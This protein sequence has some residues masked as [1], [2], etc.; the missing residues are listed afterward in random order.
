MKQII[1][2]LLIA[3]SNLSVEAKDTTT[4]K[5]VVTPKCTTQVDTVKFVNDTAWVAKKPKVSHIVYA[6]NSS[7]LSIFLD[8]LFPI[9]MLLLG[10]GIDRF[11]VWRG[12]KSKVRKTGK[13]WISELRSLSKPIEA[14][15]KSFGT[16]ITKYCDDEYNNDTP[17]VAI[18]KLLNGSTFSSLNKED[19]SEYLETI[20][21][22]D[23]NQEYQTILNIVANLEFI[24]AQFI[25]RWSEFERRAG[26][27][28]EQYNVNIQ[29]YR[30]YLYKIKSLIESEGCKN[31]DI[32]ELS[33][34]YDSVFGDKKEKFNIFKSKDTFIDPSIAI[35]RR[36]KQ[37]ADSLN[38]TELLINSLDCIEYLRNE[39]IYVKNNLTSAID[40]YNTIETANN[41]VLEKFVKK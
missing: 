24:H 3:L 21:G 4:I 41:Q 11:I 18:Y 34:L 37:D 5:S 39:K 33:E 10:V 9:I 13:R 7:G 19:L 2:I 26:L 32:Q 30:T 17:R 6:D 31:P 29:K 23:H 35:I 25:E 36:F 20:K 1:I 16:C 22:L 15:K 12:E 38:L 27:Y 8:Y 14:Q 28:T 40:A